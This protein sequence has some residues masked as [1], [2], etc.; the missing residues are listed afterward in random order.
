MII[1]ISGS[2]GSGKSTIVVMISKKLNIKRYSV[3]DFRR[4][5]AKEKNITLEQLNKIGEKE[6][7][8][9]RRRY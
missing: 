3:G 5:L 6:D 1:T 7:F 9:D 4:N 2:A 8:T